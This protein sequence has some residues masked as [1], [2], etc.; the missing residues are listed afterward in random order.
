MVIDYH[1]G[2]VKD[3]LTVD[4][5]IPEFVGRLTASKINEK[6]A[7]KRSLI[8]IASTEGNPIACKVGYEQSVTEFYSWFGGVAPAYRRAGIADKLLAM[9]ENWALDNGFNTLRVK[10]TNRFPAMLQLLVSR[11]YQISGYENNGSLATSKILFVKALR[12]DA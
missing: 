12:S 3:I 9:Q 10:S 11:G 5:Q 2:T 6:L 1:L 4:A 8:L 7:G